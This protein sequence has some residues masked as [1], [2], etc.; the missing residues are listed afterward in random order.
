[1]SLDV[2]E[3]DRVRLA[4]VNDAL[5][6]R[7][8]VTGIFGTFSLSSIAEWL[9]GIA[10]SEE[11]NAATPRAAVEGS[12]IAPDRRVVQLSR[13][14]TRRQDCGCKRFDLHS[15]DEASVSQSELE[16]EVQSAGAGGKG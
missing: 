6:V 16:G 2:F 9:A 10:G 8:K 14:H 12:S 5:D 15:A 3:K 4:F 7:E 1:M 11:M 13:V